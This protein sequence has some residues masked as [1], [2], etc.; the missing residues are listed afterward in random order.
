M[1][2]LMVFIALSPSSI[3]YAKAAD[4]AEHVLKS[5]VLEVIVTENITFSSNGYADFEWLIS[6]PDSSLADLY[7]EAFDATNYRR[8]DEEVPIPE[9]RLIECHADGFSSQSLIPVKSE[10]LNSLRQEQLLLLGFA[11]NIT[12]SSMVPRSSAG[13][14]KVFVKGY[15]WPLNASLNADRTMDVRIGLMGE[16]AV[17]ILLMKLSFAQLFLKS[18]NESQKLE[19]IWTTRI[20][21][22]QAEILNEEE[23]DGRS[24]TVDLGGIRLNAYTCMEGHTVILSEETVV[25]DQNVTLTREQAIQAF[26]GYKTLEIKYQTPPEMKTIQCPLEKV[27]EDWEGDWYAS[28]CWLIPISP[29]DISGNVKVFASVIEELNLHGHISI[30]TIYEAWM[31]FGSRT[32]VIFQLSG[33]YERDWKLLELTIAKYYFHVLCFPVEASFDAGV[34]THVKFNVEAELLASFEFEGRIKAGL[35]DSSII[36][37]NKTDA[38]ITGLETEFAA[39]LYVRPYMRLSLNFY[40]STVKWRIVGGGPYIELGPYFDLAVKAEQTTISWSFSAGLGCWAGANLE[41]PI[42]RWSWHS[43]RKLFDATFYK[44]EGSGKIP[45]PIHDVAVEGISHAAYVDVGSIVDVNVTISNH[46]NYTENVTIYGS[47]LRFDEFPKALFPELGVYSVRPLMQ[48]VFTNSSPQYANTIVNIPWEVVPKYAPIIPNPQIQPVLEELLPPPL[49]RLTRPMERLGTI[50]LPAGNVTTFTY[51]WNTTGLEPGYY[52]WLINAS[53]PQDD[54]PEN[55]GL[56]GHV[57]QVLRMGDLAVTA[58]QPY[59]EIIYEGMPLK[60]NVT[61]QNK[62]NRP[63]N[64]TLEI[65]Y[66]RTINKEIKWIELAKCNLTM[67]ANETRLLSFTLNVAGMEPCHSYNITVT[68][69]G[70]AIKGDYFD[71]NITDNSNECYIRINIMGDVNSDNR[72]DTKDIAILA[73]AFGSFPGHSRWCPIADIN[74]DNKIDIFDIAI[75]CRNFGKKYP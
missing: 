36:F 67:E 38:K 1:M 72:V 60:L 66:N 63:Q 41:V 24:W 51:K 19:F 40:L 71:K 39:G 55:N 74:G 50:V 3:L 4:D 62:E 25:N 8:L 75:T 31:E 52:V 9:Y 5:E 43:E 21:F 11:T 17:N 37:E 23:L 35:T 13:E 61:V 26:D 45:L 33:S 10:F 29:L 18:Q 73:K 47:C 7:R 2:L 22:P 68:I 15:A 34:G 64:A 56:R 27:A 70:M 57:V 49:I 14:F 12:H 30:G 6:V 48:Y 42:L 44:R 65:Y 59:R 58:I 32:T 16:K 28:W 69:K 20:A 46:G 53:I 54:L